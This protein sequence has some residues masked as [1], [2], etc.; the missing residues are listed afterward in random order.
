MTSCAGD[1]ACDER[2]ADVQP[3]GSIAD[4]T[5]LER[6]T[7]KLSL[8]LSFNLTI[9]EQNSRQSFCKVLVY[10]SIWKVLVVG[11]LP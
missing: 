11:Q 3:P 9:A 5:Y 10:C 1:R 2:Q 6:D 7:L 4:L 8:G